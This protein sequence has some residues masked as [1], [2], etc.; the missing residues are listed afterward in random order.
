M[1]TLGD[2]S[3]LLTVSQTGNLKPATHVAPE[4]YFMLEMGKE[5]QV[6]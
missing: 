5:G 6:C 1:V 3:N 4:I 2:E